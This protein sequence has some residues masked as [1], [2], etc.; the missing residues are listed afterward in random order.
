MSIDGQGTIWRRNIAENFNRLSRAHERYRRQTDDRQT[1][2]RT[3]TYSE[4]ELEFTFAKNVTISDLFI[5]LFWRWNN[6]HPMTRWPALSLSIKV[7]SKHFPSVNTSHL[8][9]PLKPKIYNHRNSPWSCFLCRRSQNSP[10]TNTNTNTPYTTVTDSS[11]DHEPIRRI[12][13]TYRPVTI[14]N[15]PPAVP[16][17]TLC[18]WCGGYQKFYGKYVFCSFFLEF[19]SFFGNS[20]WTFSVYISSA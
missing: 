16:Q 13:C 14:K 6:F 20:Y 3:M 9:F 8:T 7:H 17:A 5:F 10:N 18:V 1:D 19:L 4:H 12:P 11:T 2:G 15:V